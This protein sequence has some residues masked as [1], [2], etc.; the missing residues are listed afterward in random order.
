MIDELV[1]KYNQEP[2]TTCTIWID[3]HV[4]KQ[5]W[6][7]GPDLDQLRR[8]HCRYLRMR[9]EPSTKEWAHMMHKCSFP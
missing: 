8:Y 5:R 7:D 9:A 6:F 2:G 3:S 1:S 4:I